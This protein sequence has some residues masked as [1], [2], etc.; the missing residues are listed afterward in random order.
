MNSPSTQKKRSGIDVHVHIIGDGSN[1]TG[2]FLKL[3]SPFHHLLARYI[4]RDI[5]LPPSVLSKSNP[6]DQGLDVRYVAHLKKLVEDSSLAQVVILAHE[7]VYSPDGTAHPEKGSF[8]VPNDYVLDLAAHHPEFIA[9]ISI[10]PGRR[11]A[12]D[13][14][15]RCAARG[16][17]LLKLLPNC[18][19]VDCNDTRY[20]KFWTR[21]ADLK[22]P[23]LAHTGGELSVP[24]FNRAYANPV[25][26][27]QPLECGVNVIAAHAATSSH[28][29]DTNYLPVLT[30]MMETYSNLYTDVSA[31]CSPLRSKHLKTILQNTVLSERIVHGSDLPIPINGNWLLARGLISWRDLRHAHSTKNPLERDVRLKRALGFSEESFS[32]AELLLRKL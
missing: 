15:E 4:V 25:V 7:L 26:L 21:L 31:L 9:G 14:L 16:A 3:R 5:G 18:Q 20:K 23:F 10:H 1:G 11:D 24:V 29:L 22:I 17:R 12:L 28:P 19:N 27:R 2:C 13:E 30:K 6:P 8:Y 32:R